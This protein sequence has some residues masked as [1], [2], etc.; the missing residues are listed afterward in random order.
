MSGESLRPSVRVY[1]VLVCSIARV[2]GRLG[3]YC[4]CNDWP[5]L[6]HPRAVDITVRL[7][8]KRKG[9]RHISCGSTTVIDKLKV[10]GQLKANAC[11]FSLTRRWIIVFRVITPDGSNGLS[12]DRSRDS[13]VSCWVDLLQKQLSWPKIHKQ[14][15]LFIRLAQARSPS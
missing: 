11:S 8:L 7:L 13:C 4:W 12:G 1:E 9:G 6:F 3:K 5:V 14:N 15:R 10:S 2:F